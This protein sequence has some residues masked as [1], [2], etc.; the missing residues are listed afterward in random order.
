MGQNMNRRELFSLSLMGLMALATSPVWSQDLA[1][2]I[3]KNANQNPGNF[4]LI[5][6]NPKLKNEFYLFLKHV[7]NI[8]PEDKFHILISEAVKNSKTDQEVYAYLLAHLS[9][10]KP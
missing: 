1:D 10:M 2:F 8:Y 5:Y 3:L 4:H 6:S 7:Y 9:S